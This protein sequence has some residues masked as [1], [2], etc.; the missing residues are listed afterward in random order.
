MLW[1]STFF[2]SNPD[3]H[4]IMGTISVSDKLTARSLS[5]ILNNLGMDGP[6]LFSLNG[7]ITKAAHFTHEIGK[8]IKIFFLIFVGPTPPT[9]WTTSWEIIQWGCPTWLDMV[10]VTPRGSIIGAAHYR[11]FRPTPPT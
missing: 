7:L 3:H 2:E 6:S 11:R 1:P 10:H 5:V 8:D 4:L 9:R